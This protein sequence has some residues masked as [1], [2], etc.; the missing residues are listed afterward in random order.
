VHFCDK[1][2][3]QH[4]LVQRRTDSRG[5]KYLTGGVSPVIYILRYTG[6]VKN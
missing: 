2:E 3:R 1:G 4:D 6:P 5:Y